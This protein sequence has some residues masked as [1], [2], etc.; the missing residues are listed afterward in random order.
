MAVNIN[1]AVKSGA[2]FVQFSDRGTAVPV[3]RDTMAKAKEP[4]ERLG[5]TVA[6]SKADQV[7]GDRLTAATYLTICGWE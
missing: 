4:L 5:Y 7:E 3:D 2:R 6:V 1:G